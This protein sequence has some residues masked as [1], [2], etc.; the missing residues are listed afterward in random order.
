MH[1][2]LLLVTA[3]AT[4]A[5]AV[6]V[7]RAATS[8][9]LI[10]DVQWKVSGFTRPCTATI[11][12]YNFTISV[13]PSSGP[14]VNIP[15]LYNDSSSTPP[16]SSTPQTHSYSA[17]SCSST[18]VNGKPVPSAWQINWGYNPNGDFAV[19]T[20]VDTLGGNDAFFGWNQITST[21]SF[22]DKGPNTVYK[23]GTFT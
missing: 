18:L 5:L 23:L 11:C 3:F 1:T 19:M 17:L 22:E 13:I 16:T 2:N 6:S 4:S 14:I 8:S 7:P 15:C 20:I 9:S 12:T 21:T 10:P